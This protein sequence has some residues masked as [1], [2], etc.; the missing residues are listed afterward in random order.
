MYKRLGEVGQSLGR[1]AGKVLSISHSDVLIDVLGLQPT[2]V[3]NANYPEHNMLRLGF[4]DNSFDVVISDQVLEHLE[5]DPQRAIDECYRVLKPGGLVVHTTCF[6]NPIHDAPG[7][8]WRFTPQALELLHK[9]WSEV[10]E[11]GGW[12]NFDVWGLVRNHAR[13]IGIP[14]A[15]W[16]PLHRIATRNDPI[17]P[18]VTWV[19]ARK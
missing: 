1:Q 14:H 4:D 5:G 2:E 11:F 3:V 16:H 18:I 19:I 12:G 17:W 9:N 10:I 6:I 7:D 15:K 13:W 8:Y